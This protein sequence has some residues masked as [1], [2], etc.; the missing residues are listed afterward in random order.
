MKIKIAVEMELNIPDIYAKEFD[1]R[2]GEFCEDIAKI[3]ADETA[4]NM[5]T[6]GIGVK[7]ED[8]LW[9]KEHDNGYADG[10]LYFGA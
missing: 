1:R 10:I 5:S 9:L 2:I 7:Y 6:V 3:V 4:S 8:C